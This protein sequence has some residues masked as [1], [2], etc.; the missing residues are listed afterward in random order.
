MSA[1]GSGEPA[2]PEPPGGSPPALSAGQEQG[3]DGTVWTLVQ[4]EERGRRQIQNVLTEAEGPTLY[5]KQRVQDAVT[6]FSCLVNTEILEHIRDCTV[7]EARRVL[8]DDSWELSMHELKAFIALLYLR[9]ATRGRNQELSSF[10]SAE[11]G[12]PIFKE[13]ISRNRFQTIMRFLRFDQ[14]DTRPQR[15]E[16]NKFAL[17]NEMWDG[18]VSNSILCYKPGADITIDEQLLATKARCPFT[19]YMGNKPDKFGIKLWVAADVGSKYMLNSAPYLGKKETR[20][21]D[22]LLGESVVLKLAQPFIG[23]GRNI[24]TD[25]FFTSLKLARILLAKTTSL[26]GTVNKKKRELPSCVNKTMPLFETKVF[27][28]AQATLTI[29]QCKRKKNVC[30]LSTAHSAAGSFSGPK[31]KPEPVVYYNQTKVGV[32]VLDQMVKMYSVKAATR[33]WPVV[34]FYNMLDMAAVNAWVL[35]KKCLGLKTPRRD[36]ILELVNQLR[37]DHMRTKRPPLTGLVAAPASVPSPSSAGTADT[38][39]RQCQIRK[40]CA[41]NRSTNAC[42]KCEKVVCGQCAGEVVVV[43]LNCK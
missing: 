7:S 24:S 14:K 33:R 37:A 6:A 31:A 16:E 35:Y 21:G 17:A 25:N 23:K 11:W 39:R 8:Q 12:N 42:V 10:W 34:V 19:Q 40:N 22:L 43:C 36:F 5:A 30:I 13:T 20:S 2:Q 28:N 4:G 41:K 27:K 32:D 3:K 29:Y 15:L 38:R 1:A 18:F 9:G 26:V